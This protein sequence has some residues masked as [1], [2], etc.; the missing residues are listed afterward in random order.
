MEVRILDSASPEI[1]R[2]EGIG[3]SW[4]FGVG[5]IWVGLLAAF[6][7][8]EH[9]YGTAPLVYAYVTIGTSA[10][11]TFLVHRERASRRKRDTWHVS[12]LTG[13]AG[14]WVAIALWIALLNS[15]SAAYDW[16][17]VLDSVAFMVGAMTYFNA[18]TAAGVALMLECFISEAPTLQPQTTIARTCRIIVRGM[19]ALMA[20][21]MVLVV[22][23]VLAA[24]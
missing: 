12:A 4:Y 11:L 14:G 16:V 3:R 6:L 24:V 1:D 7:N 23:A 8:G 13:M 5:L 2:S 19:I 18:L 17:E 9:R 21:A 22:I 10:L 15:A 20:L